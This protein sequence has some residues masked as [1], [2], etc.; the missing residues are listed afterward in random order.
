MDS[1]DRYLSR[2]YPQR[3]RVLGVDLVPFTFGHAHV[4]ANA[5]EWRPFDQFQPTTEIVATGLYV[6]SRPWRVAERGVGSGGGQRFAKRLGLVAA[7]TRANMDD[8][9][10][11]F[12]EYLVTSTTGPALRP[13][14]SRAN[15]T[16]SRLAGAPLLA[17]VRL[18]AFQ[19]LHRQDGGMDMLF[20]DLLWMW[21]TY[22]EIEG[23]NRVENENERKFR[24]F[25]EEQDRKAEEVACSA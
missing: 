9:A 10:E 15:H 8:K 12:C 20:G 18:F 23:V 21:A 24:E 3:Y 13:V 11:V 5:T 6:C 16:P 14:L 4:L 7:L 1:T 25:C 22:R 2:L 19:V 17:R